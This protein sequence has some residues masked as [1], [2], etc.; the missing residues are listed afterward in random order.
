M[1]D[2][3]RIFQGMQPFQDLKHG[4][5]FWRPKGW[6]QYDM[7]DQYGIVFSPTEENPRTGFHVSVRDLNGELDG[8][9]TQADL[10]VLHEGIM[11]GLRGL[12]D[13]EVVYEK[14]ISKESAIGFEVELTF[15]Q[16]GEKYERLLYLLYNDRKQLVLYGQAVA[17]QEYGILHDIFELI[18]SSFTFGGPVHLETALDAVST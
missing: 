13:C 8:S 1:T 7:T 5:S 6:Y 2:P 3:L 12:P 15:T 10:P 16:D 18:Y 17:G 14:E 9:V 4:Y 11:R